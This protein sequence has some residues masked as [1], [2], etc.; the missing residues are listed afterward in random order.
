M[1]SSF[2]FKFF[3]FFV[4]IFPKYAAIFP[5]MCS[6]RQLSVGQLASS[7]FMIDL[8]L[9]SQ[10]LKGCKLFPICLLFCSF[11]CNSFFV[12]LS[13]QIN[14][15][16]QSNMSKVP[17]ALSLLWV[18]LPHPKLHPQTAIRAWPE[19]CLPLFQQTNVPRQVFSHALYYTDM[20]FR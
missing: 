19:L 18:G 14:I 4:N 11:V 15:H 13:M 1:L 9:Q 17:E 8:L 10:V 20:L 3:H 2:C 6:W 16:L 7:V 5:C 12:V